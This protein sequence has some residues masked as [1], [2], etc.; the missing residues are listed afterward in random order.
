MRR[1]GHER[2]S[3]GQS[4]AGRSARSLSAGLKQIVA[5]ARIR[6]AGD[7]RA[8]LRRDELRFALFPDLG[9]SPGDPAFLLDRGH[10]RHRHDDPADRRRH[11]PVGRLGRLPLDGDRRHAVPRRARPVDG[12][13]DR[14]CRLRLHRLP[15]GAM[16][17]PHR[18]AFLHRVAGLHGD[19]ARPKP[20][21]HARHAAVAVLAAAGLQVRGT[22]QPRRRALRDRHLRRTDRAV[23]RAAPPLGD[24]PARLL[25]RQRTR[26]RR[27]CRASTPSA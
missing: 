11:R 2:D 4:A 23:R 8:A 15:D 12:E 27:G 25:H 1:S 17:D 13:P 3:F 7:H 9:Q 26:R 21:L 16:R 24:L 18:A 20:A 22:G 10:R 19:H 6:A 14:D 5:R